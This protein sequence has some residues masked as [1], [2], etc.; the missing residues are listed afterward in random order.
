VPTEGPR[1]QLRQPGQVLRLRQRVPPSVLRG[2]ARALGQQLL[3]Q[4]SPGASLS[5]GDY[6]HLNVLNNS[7][8]RMCL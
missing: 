3:V 2:R 6:I 7:Y 5:L 1:A 8:N 4:P